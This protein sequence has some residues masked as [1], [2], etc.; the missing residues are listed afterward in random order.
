M[1]K[2]I[3]D[4][5]AGVG[6]AIKVRA[7]QGRAQV[8]RLKAYGFFMGSQFPHLGPSIRGGFASSSAGGYGPEPRR[9]GGWPIFGEAGRFGGTRAFS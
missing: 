2:G 7:G 3:A 8:E 9:W 6:L 1:F 4:Y 5:L